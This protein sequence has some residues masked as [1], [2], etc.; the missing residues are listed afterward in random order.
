M[1]TNCFWSKQV[2]SNYIV[3]Q[4]AWDMFL[5]HTST[6]E[7]LAGWIVRLGV[8]SRTHGFKNLMFRGT[9]TKEKP[10][11]CHVFSWGGGMDFYKVLSIENNPWAG[12]GRILAVACTTTEKHWKF[13]VFDRFHCWDI[14]LVGCSSDGLR[15][16]YENLG[17]L[18]GLALW[19]N[20][21][22][23]PWHP[24]QRAKRWILVGDFLDPGW[25]GMNLED[26]IICV[27]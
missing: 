1:N 17:R 22:L 23:D 7:G 15:M 16:D 6:L 25:T 9:S 2:S 26:F 27:F 14:G 20:C 5:K 19:Q 21:T 8:D 3:L 12:L 18:V 4:F 11:K 24:K 10:E 13:V